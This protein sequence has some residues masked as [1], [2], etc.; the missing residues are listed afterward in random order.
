M[1]N[2]KYYLFLRQYA[3]G[4]EYLLYD[5]DAHIVGRTKNKDELQGLI[6]VYTKSSVVLDLYAQEK[7]VGNGLYTVDKKDRL[8]IHIEH[9]KSY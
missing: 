1:E 8:D 6:E 3:N 7:L 2:A 4:A 5:K 9:L